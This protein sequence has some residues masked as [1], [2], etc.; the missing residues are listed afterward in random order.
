MRISCLVRLL[1][2]FAESCECG[3]VADGQFGQHLSVNVDVCL[4][5]AADELGVAHVVQSGCCVDAGDP[6]LSKISFSV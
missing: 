6:E 2:C 1:S 3:R 5:Q 4:L